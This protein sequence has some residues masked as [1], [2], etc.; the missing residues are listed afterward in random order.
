MTVLVVG[1]VALD[2]VRT[3]FGEVTEAL[4]GSC[5]YASTSASYFADVAIAAVVGSDFSADHFALFKQRGIDTSAIQVIDGGH[6]FR[7]RGFYQYDMSQA[8]TLETRLNVFADFK[9]VIPD[10][11]RNAPFVMLGNIDPDLQLEVMD[12]V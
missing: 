10:S 9:P 5:A 11:L 2:N 6:T 8:H 3:P 7:W 4:G 12:Q 1:S